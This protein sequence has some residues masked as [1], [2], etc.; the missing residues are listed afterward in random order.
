M[1]SDILSSHHLIKEANEV[2]Y[3]PIMDSYKENAKKFKNIA[4]KTQAD[5]IEFAHLNF[6]DPSHA[7][8]KLLNWISDGFVN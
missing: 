4:T 7:I 6:V 3:R 1:K 5:P 2:D 8:Q